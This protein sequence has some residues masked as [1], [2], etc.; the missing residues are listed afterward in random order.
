MEAV[1]VCGTS[2]KAGSSVTKS[3]GPRDRFAVS[4]NPAS[5]EVTISVKKESEINSVTAEI[6]EIQLIDNTGT[7]KIK[8]K[9]P[10]GT[11]SVKIATS[12]YKSGIYILRIFDGSEWHSQQLIIQH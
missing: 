5:N 8:R 6:Q 11:K 1:T 3:C 2:S 10:K 7:M 4:P 9:L 12:T